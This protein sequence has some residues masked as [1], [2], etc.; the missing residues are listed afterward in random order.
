MNEEN[1]QKELANFTVSLENMSEE[2]SLPAF[3]REWT[4]TFGQ[5]SRQNE[6]PAIL[7]AFITLFTGLANSQ[8]V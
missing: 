6:Y 5:V 1:L 8:F 3:V 2:E 4:E 7:S